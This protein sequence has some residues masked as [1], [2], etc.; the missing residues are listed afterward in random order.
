MRHTPG[1]WKYF[2]SKGHDI[3]VDLAGT[4]KIRLGHIYDDDCGNPECCNREE[5]AN[6]KIIAAAPDMLQA[7]QSIVD[8][9][10]TPQKGSM[11]DHMNHIFEIAEK[12]I[13]KATE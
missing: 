13:K 4:R 7:L 2:V 11:N 8:Y 12:A 9:W 1:P 5:H 6:A 10:N 3:M